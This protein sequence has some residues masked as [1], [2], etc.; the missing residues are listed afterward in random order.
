MTTGSGPHRVLG[1]DPLR[2]DGSRRPLRARPTCGNKLMEAAKH[3]TTPRHRWSSPGA[4]WHARVC[5]E[6]C[7]HRQVEQRRHHPAA[8]W[9]DVQGYHSG[10]EAGDEEQGDEQGHERGDRGEDYEGDEARGGV[11]EEQEERREGGQGEHEDAA[12][13][14]ACRQYVDV[15]G[16][17]PGPS[18]GQEELPP[19]R[20]QQGW[21]RHRIPPQRR[22]LG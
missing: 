13:G 10:D 19:Q 21:R 17:Q 2:A 3:A 4:R 22:L 6:Q 18:R 14:H 7:P 1:A 8:R 9:K 12:A 15:S 16:R 11:H 20:R 5:H